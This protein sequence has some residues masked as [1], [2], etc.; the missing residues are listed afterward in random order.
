MC[1][2][3][4]IRPSAKGLSG[5][6]GTSHSSIVPGVIKR[7]MNRLFRI[8]TANGQQRASDYLSIYL[9]IDL[10]NGFAQVRPVVPQGVNIPAHNGLRLRLTVVRNHYA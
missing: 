1:G 6:L 7:S 9:S 2:S 5:E 10:T 3:W 8:R 4:S